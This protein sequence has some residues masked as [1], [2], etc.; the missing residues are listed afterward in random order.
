[1]E[2][3]FIELDDSGM[4]VSIDWNGL[5][6]KL[7]IAVIDSSC[8]LNSLQAQRQLSILTVGPCTS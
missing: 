2:N 3:L 8:L 4:A 5:I 7:V 6:I 1:M